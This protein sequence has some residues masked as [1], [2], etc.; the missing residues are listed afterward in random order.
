MYASVAAT[1]AV[2]RL[3]QWSPRRLFLCAQLSRG[4][5]PLTVSESRSVTDRT[6]TPPRPCVATCVTGASGNLR[7]FT[8]DHPAKVLNQRLSFYRLLFSTGPASRASMMASFVAHR[9]VD[10]V[11]ASQGYAEGY[12]LQAGIAGSWA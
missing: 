11:V 8:A 12:Q 5:L 4:L 7:L 3:L 9:C 2:A 1:L 10:T 6:P